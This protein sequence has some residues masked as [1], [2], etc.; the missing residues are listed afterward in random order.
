MGIVAASAALPTLAG[1]YLVLFA[2]GLLPRSL[3]HGNGPHD[4]D[5]ST[6][7]PGLV[8]VVVFGSIALAGGAAALRS[9]DTMR[10]D[11]PPTDG[12]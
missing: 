8:L 1:V 5:T 4:L 11:P 12:Q 3:S 6:L 2:L 10:P 9:T 7:G